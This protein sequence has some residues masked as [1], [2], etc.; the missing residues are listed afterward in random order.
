VDTVTQQD[1]TTGRRLTW[2]WFLFAVVVYIAII[3]GLGLL[4][5]RDLHYETGT[6][7]DVETTPRS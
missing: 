5:G 1:E 6:I 7:P 2:P 3:Q 4:L